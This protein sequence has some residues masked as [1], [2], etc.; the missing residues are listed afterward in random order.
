MQMLVERVLGQ[1]HLYQ[2]VQVLTT[3]FLGLV[4]QEVFAL[5]GE[6]MDI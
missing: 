5:W 3:L 2:K 4:Y 1:V 6:K